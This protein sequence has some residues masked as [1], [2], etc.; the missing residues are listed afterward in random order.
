PPLPAERQHGDEPRR[1]EEQQLLGEPQAE[2]Q[3][4]EGQ[5]DEERRH[6]S[7]R[8]QAQQAADEDA[9]EEIND[10]DLAEPGFVELRLPRGDQSHRPQEAADEDRQQEGPAVLQGRGDR[11]QEEEQREAQEP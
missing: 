10:E 9:E 6:A 5:E 7:L 11:R 2:A 3:E 1:A 4:D 8:M